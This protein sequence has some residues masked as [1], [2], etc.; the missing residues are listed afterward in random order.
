[1]R[2]SNVL[3]ALLDAEHLHHEPARAWLR[4]NTEHG[5][6]TCSIT[7]NGDVSRHRERSASADVGRIV[8]VSAGRARPRNL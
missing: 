1:M 2:A 7:Q 3:I 5:W 6:A 4:S 8:R